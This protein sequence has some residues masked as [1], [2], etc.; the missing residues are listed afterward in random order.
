MK[1]R[2][3]SLLMALVMVV[4][5]LPATVRAA[6]GT[7]SGKGT[8]DE[9]YL[10]SNA[11]ELKAFRD[12]VNG[13]ES[14]ACAK[15]MANIDLAG[16]EWTPITS[17]IGYLDGDGHT[18]S[19]LTLKGGT[20]KYGSP[21]NTGLIGEL[22][23]SIIN[24]KMTG[25]SITENIGNWNNIGALVGKIADNSNSRIDN[26]VV[27]GAIGSSSSSSNTFIGGLVG[28]VT[29]TSALVINN[30]LSNVTLTCGNSG[31][32]G[33]LLG[34]A[35]F[36]SGT[37]SV[38]NAAVLGNITSGKYG[39]S[40]VGYFNSGSPKL[41]VNNSYVA[42]AMSGSKV[43]AVAYCGYLSSYT[44]EL[45]DFSY[46]STNNS[47]KSFQILPTKQSYE[48]NYT[49]SVNKLST[50]ELKSLTMDGFAVSA[51][52]GGYPVPKWTPV[53]KDGIPKPVEPA[54]SC[55]LT[56]TG[57]EDGVLTVKDSEGTALTSTDGVYTLSAAGDYSYS[58]TF[59]AD[60]DYNDIPETG[61]TVGEDE[62]AKTIAVPLTYKTTEPSGTGTKEAPILIGTAAELRY[63][64]EQVND[65]ELS[66][67]YVELTDN[68]TVSGSWTPLGKNTAFPFS[69]HFDGKGHSVTITVDDPGLSYF[70]FFGCLN[71]KPD[72]DSTTPIDEQPTVVV[73]NLTVNG[74]V[75]CSEPYAHVG[76]IAGCARGKVEIKNCVNNATVS[77]LARGSAGVG[78]L[79]GGYDD[80]VEYVYWNICMTLTNCVNNGTIIVTGDNEKA[81]V[82][83]M[84]G[85][86]A[87]CVQLTNC[88][89]TGT[90][91]APGCTVG[92]LL[93]EAGYQTGDFVPTIKDSSNS[94][95]LLGAA[96]KTNNL[97]G[98]GTI[99]SGYL[100]NSG[101]NTYTG[102]SES[103]DELLKESRKYNDV[104]A[105]PA[106]AGENYEI[107]LLKSGEAADEGI[108]VT[109]SVGE[110]DTN[111]AY[112][113]VVDGKLRLAKKNETGKVIEATAT[114]TWRK[115][116]KTLSK[117]VTVNI[118]PAVNSRKTLM[119]NIAETYTNSSSDWVVFDMAAYA[120][121]DGAAVKTS[122]TARENYLNLTTNELAG[123]TPLV[124]DRAK[125]EIILAALGVNS[126]K[127][128]TV[129]GTEYSNAAKL[130][131][132][133]LG[134]SH[135]TAPWVLLAEQAG[136]LKLTDAQR[137]SMIALLTDSKNLGD[138]GLFFTKWAG[139]TYADPDTTGT[140]LTAL[141][142]YADRAAVKSFIDKAVAGLSKAQNSNGSYGN[143]NS[144][145]M[146]II[147]LTAVGIDPASDER[148][149]KGGC[150]LA[151]ALLLY[152]NDTR[153]G[154]TTAAVGAVNGESTQKAA[155]LATEQGF[156]ALVTL[157]KLASLNGDSK[158]FNIYTQLVKTSASGS[159]TTTRPEK[160]SDG[161]T[162]NGAGTVPSTSTDSGTG[163]SAGSTTTA[164]WISVAVSI[165]PGSGSAWY[166]GSVR[167]AEGAT[168]E[169]ALETAA[170]QVGL[171]LN[172][173]DGYLRAVIRSGVTL[174]QYD[175]GPNS[176]WLYKVNGK[177]PN[178]GIADY[179]LNGG[180][181]VTVYYTADYTK[182]SGLDI[183][184]PASGGAVGKTETVTN[185]DGSTTKT[186]TKPD[187]TTV[188][189]TTK[190]DG[191]TT[192]AETKP[193]GSVSTVEKR[194][195][196]TEIKTAQPASGE[197][198]ASVSV[199]KSVG[200]TR[201]DIPVSKPSGS[202]VAVI[203]HPDG[204]E[205]IVKGSV[206]TE[207]G[208][209]L[210]AEG[211]VRLKIIDNAKRFNDMANHW[212]KDAVEFA[213]SRELFNGVGNDAF[214]PDLSMT[215]GMV[216]TVLA[217]LAGADTAG[218]E[219]WYAKGTVWAVENG[220][221]DGTA[222]EQPVTREQ[223][224]AMLYRYAGSPAVSGELGFDDTTVISIWAY[225][226]V[227]WCVDN[228][229]LN[230]VG[231]NR[232][233]PQDL[234]RRGQVAAM[235]MRFLQ[236]TV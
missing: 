81:F 142:A 200:S 143:V 144:D 170:A 109:C 228:G 220:I 195:D 134:S 206:V 107:T 154:F 42:G 117:P 51:D 61:F 179:P 97:Y 8:F 223:L 100:I 85:A 165:E 209:A 20:G 149:V 1:K 44:V 37:I 133:N 76:G 84:V 29:G 173:K 162:S 38:K 124:T 15:L 128:K 87:N 45:T 217:R 64:A 201:V 202:M 40:I 156:R 92:G 157:E 125:A 182:E 93:G 36:F 145:A 236:A 31:Y 66:D 80:G 94:G 67:A 95:V 190:L 105:V 54:F 69:G 161:F 16:E 189:T 148:F 43:G 233:A 73:E 211:D 60:A 28:Y 39:G 174:G 234:A 140:A 225:D 203:V 132:M 208:V 194:A 232:M 146:V 129:D 216:S 91:N 204:T 112:L 119:D 164:K 213:S 135:Y 176:G 168:V 235:L 218:G 180:E 127:L 22:N 6:D 62:T 47:D 139:E 99:R 82:G 138:D 116:D 158:S 70:G 46:D 121:L 227:R 7:L 56:F 114:I 188:E 49:G 153:N 169:Q 110:R 78:G 185:A 52:F 151:D 181:T 50:D 103:E 27:S 111:R 178:V 226:A 71:S 23:G 33:G 3:L 108:T 152:V 197:I 26:C 88:T 160:P 90:V 59:G 166:S 199:P 102:G 57:V 159:T 86:N 120:K 75:Y 210:R 34:A 183:S 137:N 230:G 163:G 32:A 184:A 13:G 171:I 96:G 79:V 104:L 65:G 205:E 177:A 231:G 63:F 175:E 207:T 12:Q 101:S 9:P 98:K 150:S 224:A 212:A 172:I 136:Q 18:I 219:T 55:A 24:V 186:E 21:V 5:L 41:T 196:G 11:D 53:D 215:R 30:C 221:S 2:A 122:D 222:P 123:N 77:S 19:G 131:D 191:S 198:T 72:R 147:G 68:I 74:T 118:Y 10:I 214:G 25:V 106:T 17:L 115:G 35:T 130:A 14:P 126:T 48:N 4:S 89:N 187:G 141:A 192:V 155:A 58:V 229:I 167:V 83:G 193:D 113:K